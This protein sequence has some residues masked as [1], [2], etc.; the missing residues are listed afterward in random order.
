MNSL[1]AHTL[2]DLL[3]LWKDASPKAEYAKCSSGLVIRKT[4]RAL[5]PFRRKLRRSDP[6][7]AAV[8]RINVRTK[9]RPDDTAYRKCCIS[10][11]SLVSVP[12][13]D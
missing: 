11:I 12:P 10:T 8:A 9:R 6:E 13:N 4:Q 1:K 3:S 5:V 2:S 7:Q